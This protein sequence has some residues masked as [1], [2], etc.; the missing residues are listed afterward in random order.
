MW[1]INVLFDLLVAI[2]LYVRIC[3]VDLCRGPAWPIYSGRAHDSPHF[4]LLPVYV[5][6][7]NGR[8]INVANP[9]VPSCYL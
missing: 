6:P 8:Y 3:A 4:F 7:T 2:I 9:S 1:S 5:L